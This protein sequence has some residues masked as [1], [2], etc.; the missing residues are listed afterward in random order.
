VVHSLQAEVSKTHVEVVSDA[1]DISEYQEGRISRA[2]LFWS[3]LPQDEQ[4]RLLSI[5]VDELRHIAEAGTFH[6]VVI[7]FTLKC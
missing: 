7:A 2:K 3:Q 5:S 1:K 6:I 4:R